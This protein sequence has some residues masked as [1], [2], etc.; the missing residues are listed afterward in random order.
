MNHE[1]ARKYARAQVNIT[2]SFLLD[3][4]QFEDLIVSLGDIWSS[5]DS[6]VIE[7]RNIWRNAGL[8]TPPSRYGFRPM[9][10][11]GS[12]FDLEG[13]KGRRLKKAIEALPDPKLEKDGKGKLKRKEIYVHSIYLESSEGEKGEGEEKSK[14]PLAL[15]FL[16][17]DLGDQEKIYRKVEKKDVHLDILI[18]IFRNGAGICTL[19]FL[20]NNT[21]FKEVMILYRMAEKMSEELRCCKFNVPE[22]YGVKPGDYFLFDLFR[23]LLKNLFDKMQIKTR[24]KAPKG[25]DLKSNT[26]RR[27]IFW[28][29]KEFLDTS[30]EFQNP[31]VFTVVKLN[32]DEYSITPWWNCPYNKWKE[33]QLSK[34]NEVLNECY[35]EA[36]LLILRPYTRTLFDAKNDVCLYENFR[37][38]NTLLDG[39]GYFKD[40]DLTWNLNHLLLFYRRSSLLMGVLKEAKPKDYFE[41]FFKY[42]SQSTLRMLEILRASWHAGLAV[43]ILLDDV[44]DKIKS[45][46]SPNNLLALEELIERRRIYARYLCDH[47]SYAF[48]GAQIVDIS[49]RAEEELWL[50]RLREMTKIK[51][52]TIDKLFEDQLKLARLEAFSS[53]LKK[54]SKKQKITKN[55]KN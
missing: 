51:F 4:N 6:N 27:E 19:S 22:G 32:K 23:E 24:R 16:N 28:V 42:F 36:A 38:P 34:E 12:R 14:S 35:K 49:A 44:I 26:Y 53:V 33:E 29:D 10:E 55:A 1:K 18:R 25:R 40:M 37:L 15:K 48:D 31:Y 11:V 5:Q 21:N 17:V 41:D 43:N 54:P 52:E 46:S 9:L 47:T 30:E 50:R 20:I 45:F 39:E 7:F 8:N 3:F 2:Y 13:N